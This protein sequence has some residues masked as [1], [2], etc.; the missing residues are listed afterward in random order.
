MTSA[1]CTLINL[2]FTRANQSKQSSQHGRVWVWLEQLENKLIFTPHVFHYCQKLATVRRV[3]NEELTDKERA[4]WS[5]PEPLAHWQ[6]PRIASLSPLN[7]RDLS[8]C[9]WSH[10]PCLIG[11][12]RNNLGFASTVPSKALEQ[13]VLRG[14]DLYSSNRSC[15]CLE[16]TWYLSSSHSA[17]D[18]T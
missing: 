9:P 1:A 4:V 7:S 11:S 10:T 16:R 15:G 14:A 6:P 17:V 3:K 5:V 2:L 12:L 13:V 18:R 8:Q